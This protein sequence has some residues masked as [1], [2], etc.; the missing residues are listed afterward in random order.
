MLLVANWRQIRIALDPLLLLFKGIISRSDFPRCVCD[1]CKHDGDDLI[2]PP[3]QKMFK[4]IVLF[5]DLLTCTGHVLTNL[6]VC[7]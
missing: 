6:F 2:I 7:T 5:E 3:Q 4:I 1:D